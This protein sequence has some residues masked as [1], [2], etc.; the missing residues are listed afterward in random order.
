FFFFFFFFSIII[1]PSI[2][3]I[4]NII[5]NITAG[6]SVIATHTCVAQAWITHGLATAWV[7][8]WSKLCTSAAAG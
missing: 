8:S 2:I 7:G 6:Q 1:T 5:T 3:I 4:I